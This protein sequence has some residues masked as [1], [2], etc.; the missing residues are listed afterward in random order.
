MSTLSAN[1]SYF[2]VASTGRTATHWL[3]EVLNRHPLIYCSHGFTWP[4]LDKEMASFGKG[5][6]RMMWERRT[7]F[8]N[9]SIG[10]F[11]FLHERATD[12]PFVG[13]VHGYS[14][15]AISRKM[16]SRE[17]AI[18]PNFGGND[19]PS[20]TI[21]RPIK[22]V[23]LIRYPILQCDSMVKRTLASIRLGNVHHQTH[24][25]QARATLSLLNISHEYV[26]ENFNAEE[27]WSFVYALG[28]TLDTVRDSAFNVPQFRMEDI[29]SRPA[30]LTRLIHA[31]CSTDISI[32]DAF[33]TESM[34]LGPRDV[35]SDRA[36]TAPEVFSGWSDW[37][38]EIFKSYFTSTPT[39]ERVER[40]GYEL[41]F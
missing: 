37:K 41:P 30:E 40:Q 8:E 16:R 2:L 4:K 9:F 27:V 3:S 21:A 22:I 14:M 7:D 1:R 23:N 26:I 32:P 38:C 6:S 33:C 29:V 20:G 35:T 12:K 17:D 19:A 39:R 18:N 10:Q 28:I 36:R 11:L 24:L 5:S 15:G 13:N 31:I 34:R 25:H